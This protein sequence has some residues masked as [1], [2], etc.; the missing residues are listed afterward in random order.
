[1]IAKI[2][3]EAHKLMTKK[4]KN[5]QVQG[6]QDFT[7]AAVDTLTKR[8]I[9]F[10]CIYCNAKNI[11][12]YHTYRK[13][14][15][16]NSYPTTWEPTPYH[17]N[18]EDLKLHFELDHPEQWGRS[19]IDPVGPQG[20]RV[21]TDVH[22]QKDRKRAL[23][24]YL[25]IRAYPEYGWNPFLLTHEPGARVPSLWNYRGGPN[26]T[27]MGL[28]DDETIIVGV[29]WEP[30]CDSAT[31]KLWDVSSD[32]AWKHEKESRTHTRAQN[33]VGPQINRSLNSVRRILRGS[34]G[35]ATNLADGCALVR[36][37]EVEGHFA[38]D[39]TKVA[40]KSLYTVNCLLH[41]RALSAV[42]AIRL[43]LGVEG[44]GNL[45]QLQVIQRWQ[46]SG[47]PHYVAPN[48]IVLRDNQ[49]IS[50]LAK[51]TEL[52][53]TNNTKEIQ[54]TVEAPTASTNEDT[55][56]AVEQTAKKEPAPNIE[57]DT[58]LAE[59]RH[60]C[61]N[62]EHFDSVFNNV[63]AVFEYTRNLQNQLGDWN[64][65]HLQEQVDNLKVD[66]SNSKANEDDARQEL[67]AANNKL[68]TLGKDPVSATA[69]AELTQANADLVTRVAELQNQLDTRPVSKQQQI[70][71]AGEAMTKKL[72]KSG[73]ITVS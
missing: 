20:S 40:Y 6:N 45:G 52:Q 64:L 65:T 46:A 15:K 66:V 23:D 17:E 57:L 44:Q 62:T 71:N 35:N 67:Q 43:R 16:L 28:P 60:L 22:G 24:I 5:G 10:S 50:K 51:E 8:E 53:V 19:E 29:T 25:N 18:W 48:G 12:E 34:K 30:R 27:L 42:S 31:G 9:G 21:W 68:A 54:E 3:N 41:K 56:V 61:P 32:T 39:L 59:V 49:E 69:H 1:M 4:H 13:I 2:L 7:E 36:N 58:L 26:P 55:T 63:E 47:I 73:T 70:A 37:E 11:D 72:Q 14:V 38:I 33:A